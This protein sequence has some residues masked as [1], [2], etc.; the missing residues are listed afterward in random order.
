VSAVIDFFERMTLLFDI[1]D[2]STANDT[3][4]TTPSS[5]SRNNPD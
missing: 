4:M 2:L 1:F 5:A 3:G